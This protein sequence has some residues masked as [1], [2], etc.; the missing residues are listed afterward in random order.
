V[1]EIRAFLEAEYPDRREGVEEFGS[2]MRELYPLVCQLQKQ[3]PEALAEGMVLGR[4]ACFSFH[5]WEKEPGTWKHG[6]KR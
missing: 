5:E 6:K 1:P 3:L 4:P 2:L